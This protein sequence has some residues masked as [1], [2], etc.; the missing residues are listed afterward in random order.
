MSIETRSRLHTRHATADLTHGTQRAYK[1]GCHCDRC[2]E[3]ARRAANIYKLNLLRSGARTTNPT[4]TRRRV[5]ALGM[6]GWPHYR[7]AVDAGLTTRQV[8]RIAAGECATVPVKSAA[9]IRDVYDALSMTFAP[10]G[11]NRAEKVGRALTVRA[12]REHGGFVPL[13]WDDDQ[14]DN[15]AAVPD[16]GEKTFRPTGGAGR[17]TAE[18]VEDVEW[19]L[20]QHPYATAA[21]IAARLGYADAS[22]IQNGLKHDRGNRPDLL[23]QLARNA[24]VAA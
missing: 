8:Q 14:I 3:G 18:L 23:T 24:E 19:L 9:A 7:I 16:L 11:T 1:N 2:T 12:A 4:G 6:L 15:P 5:L 20:E 22:G 17:P 21:E 13:A 10:A